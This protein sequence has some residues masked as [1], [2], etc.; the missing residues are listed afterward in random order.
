MAGR[1]TNK[2]AA[3]AAKTVAQGAA[4]GYEA[5]LWALA[6]APRGSMDA[7]EWRGQQAAAARLDAEIA[8]NLTALGF[9]GDHERR[10]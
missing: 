9:G 1:R 10:P 3:R 2:S 7:A 8:A 6:D 5:G 4:T